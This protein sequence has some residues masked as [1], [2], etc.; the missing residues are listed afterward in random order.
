MEDI[1]TPTELYE[2]AGFMVKRLHQVATALFDEGCRQYNMTPSQYQA[3]CALHKYPAI[4][5]I[6]LGKLTGQDRSTVGLVVRLLLERGLIRRVVNAADKRRASLKLAPAGVR[7][8]RETAPAAR[9]AQNRFL[10][11]LPEPDRPEFLRLLKKLVEGHGANIDPDNVVVK[12]V[13]KK[14]ARPR[15][16]AKTSAKISVKAAAKSASV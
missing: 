5:Q 8:L 13:V 12:D 15:A 11:A 3:L 14:A 9:Q 2:R 10:A 1:E 16:A 6:A 7:I 4:D